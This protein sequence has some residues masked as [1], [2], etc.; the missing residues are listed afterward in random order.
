MSKFK[1]PLFFSLALLPVA[2]VGGYLAALVA[3]SSMEPSALETAIT[4]IGSKQLIAVISTVQPVILALISG[5]FGY[6][7]AE[8][9]G[10]MRPFGLE[11]SKVLKTA[12][13]SLIGGA[14][15]S[16]D[17]WT[18]AKWIPELRYDTAGSFDAVT[19][20]ASILYGGIVEEVMLR[21][22]FMSLL[23]F[24]A[25][26]LFF[27]KEQTIPTGV[28]I[29]ANIIAAILFAAGH[30][31]ATVQAFGGLTPMLLFRC[32][33]MNGAFGLIFGRLYR[34]YGIQYA[35]LAHMLFHVVSK[36]VW[37]IAF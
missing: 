35:M 24:L 8:K 30:L 23:S 26:K 17:A 33:L 25:W 18:F 16:L 29:G 32:F 20:A 19:W 21:L 1:K 11:K 37:M 34:K 4:Q 22:L 3:I 9:V 6:I 27:R 31:P 12:I 13:I 28:F 7:L 10:L 36:T 15:F 5:F 14:L 2:I